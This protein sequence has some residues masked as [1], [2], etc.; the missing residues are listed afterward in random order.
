MAWYP[1]STGPGWWWWSWSPSVASSSRVTHSQCDS[2]PGC[3][4][5]RRMAL[6]ILIIWKDSF[7]LCHISREVASLKKE[8]HP[9]KRQAPNVNADCKCE[10]T[11]SCKVVS[12]QV[13][14]VCFL[15]LLRKNSC[16]DNFF[17]SKEMCMFRFKCSSSNLKV[18]NRRLG[19]VLWTFSSVVGL[20]GSVIS[21]CLY[22]QR[23]SQAPGKWKIV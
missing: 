9:F 20:A 3:K 16:L 21:F 4:L 13:V 6:F 8:L 7:L 1:A 10:W 23:K 19:L 15:P 17:G 14:A 11:L 18:S 5:S 2:D 22:R 12:L